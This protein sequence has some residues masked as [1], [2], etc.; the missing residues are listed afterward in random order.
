MADF[1]TTGTGGGV[2]G[3][4][5]PDN[6]TQQL[7][8]IFYL[9]IPTLDADFWYPAIDGDLPLPLLETTGDIWLS[10]ITGDLDLPS[11]TTAGLITV[12]YTLGGTIRLP[13]IQ[14]SG[15][16]G[17]SASLTLPK[18]TTAGN[19][20][21][22]VPISASLRLP[23]LALSAAVTNPL[24]LSG[25]I[26][27]PKL[28][29][30]GA[31]LAGRLISASL[32]TP[33]F[34]LDGDI[35][36][37]RTL[38]ADISL[39]AVLVAG[40][41][42][43]GILFDLDATLPGFTVEGGISLGNGYSV[44]VINIENYARTEYVNFPFNS[45]ISFDGKAYGASADGIFLLEGVDDD[46]DYVNASITT[47][48]SD[49]GTSLKK[50]VPDV[51]MGYG[52]DGQI[53]IRSITDDMVEGSEQVKEKAVNEIGKARIKM[54][55]GRMS[56]YWGYKVRNIAGASLQLDSIEPRQSVGTR[57]V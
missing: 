7:G 55:M 11:I 4:A 41:V 20:L 14:V 17:I 47:G 16:F 50:N 42:L 49:L 57:R 40:E 32:S 13:L 8:G 36:A 51:Y 21:A 52:T 53:G 54:P 15:G 9:L 12:T 2:A 10:G 39:N 34:R 25:N 45:M 46:G 33:A 38:A 43:Q 1:A 3:G 18:V 56:R 31:V 24:L 5:N 28:K 37:G 48:L 29:T 35:I 26:N 19:I 30:S 22:G 27:L 44:L 6:A 23:L